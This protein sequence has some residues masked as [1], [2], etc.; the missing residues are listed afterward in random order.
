[1]LPFAPEGYPFV[2][3]PALAGIVVW[4]FGAPAVA[5][6]CWVAMLACVAFFRDP[7]RVSAAPPEVVLAPADGKVL[8]VGSAPAAMTG[9]GLPQQISIFM[10]PA[11]VH[12]NRAPISG[13]VREARYTAGAKLPAF[14]DKA[15]ELNEHSFVLLEGAL[16]TVAYK[17]IAGSLARRVVCDLSPGQTVSRGE[18]V[19]LI[20]F[21]SRV[22]LFLPGHAAVDVSPGQRT[23]AGITAVARL[24]PGGPA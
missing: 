20:K 4:A 11:N 7:A 24:S 22:D 8:S 5:A 1:M 17:Q 18:R 3:V 10:S 12:V 16:G 14:R 19:G 21:G 13:T 6:V 9:I 2:L 15:S 23:R